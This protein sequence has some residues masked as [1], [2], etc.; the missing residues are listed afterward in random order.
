MNDYQS[1]PAILSI[2]SMARLLNLSREI[3]GDM[4][5]GD[6]RELGKIIRNL[7]EKQ[8]ISIT[9]FAAPSL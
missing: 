9:G 6:F 8:T 1:M 5:R 3:S 2:S 4:V 7:P